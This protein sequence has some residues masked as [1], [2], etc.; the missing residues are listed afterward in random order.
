MNELHLRPRTVSE[1]VDAAFQLYRRNPLP[2]LMVGAV[3]FSPAILLEL[4]IPTV[5]EPEGASVA[6][7]VG[8][9]GKQLVGGISYVLGGALITKLGSDAYLGGQPDVAVAV[10]HVAPRAG[11][12]LAAS[13]F[14]GF[15]Y[16]LGTLALL[17][18]A[19]YVAARYFAVGAVVVLEDKDAGEAF[20]RS[21]ELSAGRKR[22]VLNTLLLTWMI[23]GVFLI[24]VSAA[25]AVFQSA[26]VSQLVGSIVLIFG[27]PLLELTALVL[28]YDARIRGEG[29]DLEQMAGA[30]DA[31]S[32]SI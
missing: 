31:P 7:A 11:S 13:L 24:G 21:T 12:V 19:L 32:V 8:A 22:H 9:L 2:Y 16:T 28:Y 14:K 30:L 6:G 23:F 3:A 29:F 5:I 1:L 4:L 10:R 26:V 15:L 25:S 18:G 17:V 20:A 27:L